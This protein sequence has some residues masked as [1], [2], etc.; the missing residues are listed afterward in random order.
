MKYK[1]GIKLNNQDELKKHWHKVRY[2]L[3]EEKEGKKDG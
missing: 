1:K 2:R 3:N